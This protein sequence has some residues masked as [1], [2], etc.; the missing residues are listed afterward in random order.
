MRRRDFLKAA[1]VSAG[2]GATLVTLGLWPFEPL[3]TE[4]PQKPKPLP[5]EPGTTEPGTTEPG[6]TEPEVIACSPQDIQGMTL[7]AV[8]DIMA[9]T[10][11]TKS[12]KKGDGTF[13]Y[14]SHFKYLR[15]LFQNADVVMGNLETPLGGGPYRGYPL[16]NAPDQLATDLKWSG[17]SALNL[18][19]NHSLDQGWKGLAR[20]AEVVAKNNLLYTGAFLSPEDR[21]QPRLFSAG[22]V[23]V[24]FLGYTYGANIPVR[25]PKGESWRLNLA[26]PE[27]I[28]PDIQSLKSIGADFTVINIHF[29]NEYHLKPNKKQLKLVEALFAA[30]ADLIIGHHPHVVQ[31]GIM[32]VGGDGAQAAIFSLGNFI[33][34]QRDRHTDQALMVKANFSKDAEGRK[35]LGPIDLIQTR[36]IRR[37]VDGRLN[38]RVL[39]T[40]QAI[41]TPELYG[42]TLKD[43]KLLQQ[44]YLALADRLVKY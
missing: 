34:N 43:V 35:V 19:N 33:S 9:H 21:A 27:V 23:T 42:L 32:K 24:G 28:I 12:A 11:V 25:Y 41:D 18:A 5:P 3:A 44:D 6:T 38:Y 17:F 2:A 7:M 26:Q 14:R 10:P 40:R 29:G 39:P 8:G 31:P 22:G 37:V 16:F 1:L 13:D 30:G 36:C 15:P 4:L 20:T